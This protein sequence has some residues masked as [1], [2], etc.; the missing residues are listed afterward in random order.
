[1]PGPKMTEALLDGWW[2]ITASDTKFTGS[3]GGEPFTY[4]YKEEDIQQMA[5]GYDP[6]VLEAPVTI[7]HTDY[8]QAHGW[9]KEL[10]VKTKNGRLYLQ[11]RL[12]EL[13]ETLREALLDG[14]YRSRSAEVYINFKNTRKPY[15]AGLAFLGAG[16]P[17]MINLS[18]FPSLARGLCDGIILCSGT[19]GPE[20]LTFEPVPEKFNIETKEI[21]KMD[22]ATIKTVVTDAMNSFL[23]KF[24]AKEAED[25]T[26]VK[27]KAAEEGKAEA[28]SKIEAAEK[29]KKEAEDK[30]K[31][32]E[33]EGQLAIF[34]AGVEK[35]R[36]ESRITP[37]DAGMYTKLGED[38][39]EEK[40]KVILEDIT[41]R[42]PNKILSELS[43]KSGDKNKA[44]TTRTSQMRK[45]SE[46]LWAQQENPNAKDKK[47]SLRAFDLM[48][49]DEKLELGEAQRIAASE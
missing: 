16:T 37:A 42:E 33:A 27:L 35:A 19:G 28:E 41:A 21:A 34:K 40:R 10:R 3:R 15:L 23:D 44:K 6:E 8:G 38:L 49:A 4:N 46:A 48:D 13:S 18:P 1:M 39:P 32:H 47:V 22:T 24:K 2:D 12:K 25:E 45:D 7:E 11:A 5:E 20:D 36:D 9:I 29:A 31:A 14:G 17:A 30:L 26:T 43:G